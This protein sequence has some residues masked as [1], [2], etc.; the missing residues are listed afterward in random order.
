MPPLTRQRLGHVEVN[1]VETHTLAF[2]KGDK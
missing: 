2:F 1:A